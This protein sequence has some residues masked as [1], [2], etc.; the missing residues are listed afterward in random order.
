MQFVVKVI[1]IEQGKTLFIHRFQRFEQAYEFYWMLNGTIFFEKVCV[2]L[3]TADYELI[4][5]F[6]SRAPDQINNR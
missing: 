1:S 5:S 3:L 6:E 2:K 4:S